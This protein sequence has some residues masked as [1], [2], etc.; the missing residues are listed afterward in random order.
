MTVELYIHISKACFPRQ[1]CQK[2]I[3]YSVEPVTVRVREATEIIFIKGSLNKLTHLQNCEIKYYFNLILVLTNCTYFITKIWKLAMNV[4]SNFDLVDP[5]S[6]WSKQYQY[7]YNG[8][9]ISRTC[10]ISS[11][12]LFSVDGNG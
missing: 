2:L 11:W 7:K 1:A 6:R 3:T 9:V 5:F 10:I 8:K 4:S 12:H